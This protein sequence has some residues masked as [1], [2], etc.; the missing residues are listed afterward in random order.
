MTGR[1]FP[2]NGAAANDGSGA[3]LRDA[4][5][6]YNVALGELYDG[7]ALL[8]AARVVSDQL[9]VAPASPAVGAAYLVAAGPT[10]V[11]AGH[12]GA[13]AVYEGTGW[14]YVTPGEGLLAWIVASWQ[15][16]VYKGGQWVT[17]MA[18]GADDRLTVLAGLTLAANQAICTDSYGKLMQTTATT[19]GKSLLAMASA[20]ALRTELSAQPV[21]ATLT[22][23]AG[24]TTAADRLIYATGPD[25]FAISPLSS[26]MR[27]LLAAPSKSSARYNLGFRANV[28]KRNKVT[29]S[30]WLTSTTPADNNWFAIC[31]A[32]ELGLYC[33]I[34]QTGSGNS[35]MTS[36]DGVT[37]TARTSPADNSWSGLCWA[38][39]L[40]LFVAVG[41]SGTGNRV[42]TSPDGIN[43][44][45]R[46]SAA[47]NS[48]RSVCWA[49]ELGL[50]VAV[51]ITG[52][53]NRVMTSP[54]GINWTTRASAADYS[55]SGVCWSAELS[56]LVAV[57]SDVHSNP[58]MTSP[59]G[60]TWTT[61]IAT[62]NTWYGVCWAAELGLFMAV[63]NS[64]TGNRV[65]TSPD[66]I[67]WT[68]RASA[69]D[70]GWVGICWAAE[71]GLAV[72][73]AITGTGNRV[74]TSPDGINWTLRTSAADNGWRAVCWAPEPGLL[75]AVAN[76][77]TG[78]RAMTSVSAHAL[79]YRSA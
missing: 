32:A 52:S 50:L 74:M 60:I 25:A 66:G 8:R 11:W 15:L 17:L 18:I 69:A 41:G 49:A 35:I 78:N 64:G 21:D 71:I 37:W 68:T 4:T 67:T 3:T 42:M 36:P 16:R 31:W 33:A 53:G 61:R 43:W 62:S 1:N 57:A 12:A 34:A 54:D 73:V 45:L 5:T 39:E 65:M 14:T 28:P 13:I 59:D 26:Y 55:W 40:G 47:D 58:V 6:A 24:L 51:A 70:N 7:L 9:A 29:G 30:S 76:S 56:L 27:T 46:T 23:L 72:P 77:G 79:T 75:A 63:A 22:A 19:F 2:Y 48:W 20:A 10:G 44:T 38:A